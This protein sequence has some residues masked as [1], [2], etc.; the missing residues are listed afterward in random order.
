M[1]NVIIH[2]LCAYICNY[3]YTQLKLCNT[4]T[5]AHTHTHTCN[6]DC[7]VTSLGSELNC[8]FEYLACL[9]LFK[10]RDLKVMQHDFGYEIKHIQ[11]PEV[12][13]PNFPCVEV[14]LIESRRLIVIWDIHCHLGQVRCALVDQSLRTFAARRFR[15]ISE[16]FSQA[17]QARAAGT[18]RSSAGPPKI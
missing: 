11:N 6:S 15:W 2:I 16:A 12:H 3:V 7:I 5:Y 8:S 17:S 1:N 14:D 9:Q 4:D 18:C 13:I 10:P